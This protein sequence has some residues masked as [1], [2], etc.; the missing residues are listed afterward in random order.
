M[1]AIGKSEGQKATEM[2]PPAK[3][4]STWAIQSRTAHGNTKSGK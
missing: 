3:N 1:S 4:T 2:K